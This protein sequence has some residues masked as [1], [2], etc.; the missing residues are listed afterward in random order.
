MFELIDKNELVL[1]D[2]QRNFVW[3]KA[4]QKALAAS[5]LLNLFIGSFLILEGKKEDFAT[6]KVGFST[7]DATPTDE[8]KF[9]LDGQQRLTSLKGI[10]GDFFDNSDWKDVMKDIYSSLKTKCFLR[11]IPEKGEEDMDT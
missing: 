5:V 8:C 7:K 3:N 4:G 1:P 11:V 10:F 6:K 9:L 2:F